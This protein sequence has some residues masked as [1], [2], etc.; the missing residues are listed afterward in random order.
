MTNPYTAETHAPRTPA[1]GTEGRRSR[2]HGLIY[3]TLILTSLIFLG[4]FL[5]M[6]STSLKHE[7]RIFPRA[8][9][10]PQW[11]PTTDREDAQGRSIVQYQG[12]SGVI[13]GRDETGRYRLQIGEDEVL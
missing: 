13:L 1:G 7:S 2:P 3:L 12:R 4:P 9:E 11:L 8:G 5:W 6:V 10:A